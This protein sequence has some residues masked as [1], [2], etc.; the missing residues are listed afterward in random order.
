MDFKDSFHNH[1]QQKLVCS[2][3]HEILSRPP[4]KNLVRKRYRRVAPNGFESKLML[5]LAK[6]SKLSI[7]S[8]YCFEK[9]N[10]ALYVRFLEC[11]KDVWRCNLHI[12]YSVATWRQR[13]AASPRQPLL[14][15]WIEEYRIISIPIFFKFRL[16]RLRLLLWPKKDDRWSSVSYCWSS[17]KLSVTKLDNIMHIISRQFLRSL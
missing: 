16:M 13:K 2:S 15:A 8:K 6:T 14:T 10:N 3:I 9:V 1:R 12:A 5:V 17:D 7:I 11:L 4:T